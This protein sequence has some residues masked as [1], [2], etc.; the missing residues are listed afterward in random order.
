MTHKLQRVTR[1]TCRE[2]NG[3]QQYELFTTNGL[4]EAQKR[5]CSFACHYAINQITRAKYGNMNSM[6]PY[7]RTSDWIRCTGIHIR[8][9]MAIQPKSAFKLRVILFQSQFEFND[10]AK[11]NKFFSSNWPFKPNEHVKHGGLKVNGGMFVAGQENEDGIFETAIHERYSNLF[12][13]QRK[14]IDNLNFSD[15]VSRFKITNPHATPIFDRHLFYGN[16]GK[17]PKKLKYK[18]LLPSRTTWVYPPTVHDDVVDYHEDPIPDRKM[19]LMIIATPVFGG[20]IIYP[21]QEMVVDPVEETFD[22]PI[23]HRH[24]RQGSIVADQFGEPVNVKLEQPEAGPSRIDKGKGPAHSTRS[25]TTNAPD[26][27]AD[28]DDEPDDPDGPP[29]PSGNPEIDEMVEALRINRETVRYEA[30]QR[31]ANEPPSKEKVNEYG[32]AYNQTIMIRP[33]VELFFKNMRK[34]RFAK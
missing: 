29:Q 28:P 9:D 3:L 23:Q 2:Q 8:L 1:T 21:G 4:P 22:E 10:L 18:R 24:E 27:D 15:S 5:A 17:T 14:S 12:E 33:T 19:Y 32:W 26:P 11:T 34:G 7:F 25:K 16:K 20:D 6:L 13:Y 30:K 31:K